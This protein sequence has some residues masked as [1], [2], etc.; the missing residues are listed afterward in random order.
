MISEKYQCIFV[1]IP[2]VAG[3]SIEQFFLDLHGLTWR[4]RDELLLKRN[5]N[6]RRG[7]ERLAHLM[8]SEYVACG[9]ISPQDFERYYS[10]A[11]V[12]NPW[13]RLVSEYRYRC[14]FSPMSFREFV[15]SACPEPAPF[16]DAKRHILPQYD[17]VHNQQGELLV[18]FV[19][20]FENLQD[21]FNTVC[22]ALNLPKSTLPRVNTAAQPR[23]LI[24]R[25]KQLAGQGRGAEKKGHYTEYY[26]DE[27]RQIVADRYAR[28]IQAFGYS[29]GE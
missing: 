3:Q 19:G 14:A 10:F 15:R 9:H 4:R 26:D 13:D 1:H 17:F 11:F 28:S 7:P 22:Q 6:P 2:K 23:S 29:F 5:R 21:D 16:S 18:D 12:R 20:R 25:L 24:G 8:A 27:L